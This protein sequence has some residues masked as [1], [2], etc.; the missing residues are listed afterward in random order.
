MKSMLTGIVWVA[1]L[2]A[3]AVGSHL[4]ISISGLVGRQRL[5]IEDVTLF[6]YLFRAL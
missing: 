5:K 3:A 2:W 1:Y 4:Q 6:P